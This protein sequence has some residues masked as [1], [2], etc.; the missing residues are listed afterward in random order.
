VTVQ[1]DPPVGLVEHS[2]IEDAVAG[3]RAGRPAA[4]GHTVIP[5]NLVGLL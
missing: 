1:V 3:I 5:D 4:T 2:M